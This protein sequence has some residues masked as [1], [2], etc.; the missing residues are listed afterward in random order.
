LNYWTG[1]LEFYEMVANLYDSL[2]VEKTELGREL[3][4]CFYKGDKY[5]VFLGK[6]KEIP[7]SKGVFYV[8]E[9]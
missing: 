8:V 5:F 6:M 2:Y 3:R 9:K 4:F 1:L 7:F